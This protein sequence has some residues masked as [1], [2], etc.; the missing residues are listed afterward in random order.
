M[1]KIIFNALLLIFLFIGNIYIKNY[2]YYFALIYSCI[3]IYHI[4]IFYFLYKERLLNKSEKYYFLI[5]SVL[6]YLI[7]YFIICDP[8]PFSLFFFYYTFNPCFIKG[9]LIIFMHMLFLDRYKNY[10]RNLSINLKPNKNIC[11][12]LL[13]DSFFFI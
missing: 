4:F 9:I 3:I 5:T 2:N 1:K 8:N 6:L 13:L 7:T 12:N 10:Y 11:F